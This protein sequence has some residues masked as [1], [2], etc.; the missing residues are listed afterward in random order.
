ME[1]RRFEAELDKLIRAHARK[2]HAGIDAASC[3]TRSDWEE[4]QSADRAFR[5]AREAF[6]AWVFPPPGANMRDAA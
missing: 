4:C 3:G 2:V 5:A 1:R 6:I